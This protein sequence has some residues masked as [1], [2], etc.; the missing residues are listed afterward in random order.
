M[1]APTT[2]PVWLSKPGEQDTL[3]LDLA[4]Y[5]ATVARGY[6]FTAVTPTTAIAAPAGLTA[7]VVETHVSVGQ[8][9]AVFDAIAHGTR[10]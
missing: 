1:T 10:K 7:A 5:N 9:H 8:P 4:G 6:G 2:F 3:V